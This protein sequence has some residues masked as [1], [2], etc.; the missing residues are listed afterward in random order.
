[1]LMYYKIYCNYILSDD[2]INQNNTALFLI[3]SG[4]ALEG[5]VYLRIKS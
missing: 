4:R 5:F 2:A 3:L 1:M